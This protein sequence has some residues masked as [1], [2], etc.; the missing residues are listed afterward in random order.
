MEEKK[1]IVTISGY[2]DPLHIGHIEYCE[3]AR[4][5][6]DLK[7]AELWV[8]VNNDRQTILKKGQAFMPEQER[9]K[10]MGS[11]KGVDKAV[12]SIDKDGSQVET[13][14]SIKPI[15]FANGGD[16]M[17]SNIPE[18]QTCLANNIEIID[19]LGEKIQSSSNLIAQSEEPKEQ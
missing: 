2:F 11:L 3:H 19:G 12:L 5:L 16:R 9:L 13:L 10:I 1:R 15:I 7:N 17:Q 14:K 6:A 18:T 8:I 4:K